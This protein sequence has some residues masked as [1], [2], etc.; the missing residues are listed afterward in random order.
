MKKNRVLYFTH[1]DYFSKKRKKNILTI[2]EERR[3]LRK[4]VEATV[5][6]FVC[7]MRKD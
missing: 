5:N 1:D 2:P 3:R 4:N 7:K 6:E